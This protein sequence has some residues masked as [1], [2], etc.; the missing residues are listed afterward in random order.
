MT[1]LSKTS[2]SSPPS[3]LSKTSGTSPPLDSRKLS[4]LRG[5]NVRQTI[6]YR[7][8]GLYLTTRRFI[9]GSPTIDLFEQFDAPNRWDEQDLLTCTIVSRDPASLRRAA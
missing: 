9:L 3:D 4:I 2:G 5:R 6:P 8:K 1:D 7:V